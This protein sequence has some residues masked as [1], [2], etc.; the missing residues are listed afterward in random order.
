MARWGMAIYAAMRVMMRRCLCCLGDLGLMALDFFAV[1]ASAVRFSGVFFRQSSLSSPTFR[2]S[3]YF[4]LV[5][6]HDR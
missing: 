3:P 1:F 2:R 6:R 4:S 5:P